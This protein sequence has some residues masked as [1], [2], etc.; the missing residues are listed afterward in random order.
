MKQA[1]A[2]SLHACTI[3]SSVLS[4]RAGSRPVRFLSS[5]CGTEES[6]CKQ[7]SLRT[8]TT[9]SPS[10]RAP[11]CLPLC[12]LM[13]RCFPRTDRGPPAPRPGSQWR[14][15]QWS[16]GGCP[17]RV[18]PPAPGPPPPSEACYCYTVCRSSS[19]RRETPARAFAARS[20]RS[21]SAFGVSLL[22]N[23]DLQLKAVV[24]CCSYSRGGFLSRGAPT[25][26]VTGP[27]LGTQRGPHVCLC[28]GSWNIDILTWG[29]LVYA[30]CL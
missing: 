25:G 21:P 23:Q 19:G 4:P 11:S 10:R 18:L 28:N 12:S 26:R 22:S 24:S 8:S 3:L 1:Q 15:C 17:C 6:P 29:Q 20:R 27:G 14:W 7:R 2:N 30:K 5:V 13:S 16:R 9:F